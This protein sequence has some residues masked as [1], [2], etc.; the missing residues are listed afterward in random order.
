MNP[1]YEVVWSEAAERDLIAIVQYIA[2]DSPARAFE[3]LKKIRR[4][5]SRLRTFPD[6]GRIVPEL[7]QQGINQYHELILPPWRV[8]YRI[9]TKRVYVLT[10]LDS[11][12]SVEDLLLQRL[13]GFNL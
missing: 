8:I 2:E 5:A 4:K 7:R 3:I 10:V 12:R 13:T 9:S 11:R 1:T 6:R